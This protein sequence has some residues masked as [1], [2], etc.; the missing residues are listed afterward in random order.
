MVCPPAGADCFDL[1]HT[2]H[3]GTMNI[4]SNASSKHVIKSH[5]LQYQCLIL[6]KK[7]STELIAG[8]HFT[9][10]CIILSEDLS[11]HCLPSATPC[12]NLKVV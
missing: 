12:W 3:V 1:G 6:Q 2:S 8:N 4:A 5:Q 11:L 10:C 7:E 9:E